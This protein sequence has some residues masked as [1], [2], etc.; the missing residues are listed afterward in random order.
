M[1]EITLPGS[2]ER[3][4]HYSPATKWGDLLFISGQLPMDWENGGRLVSGGV[5]EQTLQ[6]LKNLQSVLAAAGLGLEDVAKVTVFVAG[7]ELWPQVDQVYASF[8]GS[9]R[10]ARSVVPTQPLHYGALVE[11][12]AI[13]CG[14]AK[15]NG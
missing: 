15:R 4:G 2:L 1:Q 11:V 12:E 6:S 8:F 7:V 3:P 9:L 14:G 10:P 5:Q 13:A